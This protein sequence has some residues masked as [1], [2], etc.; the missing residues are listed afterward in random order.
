[1]RLSAEIARIEFGRTDKG[2]GCARKIVFQ[3]DKTDRQIDCQTDSESEVEHLLPGA[4][5][6]QL[7]LATIRVAGTGIQR[8]GSFDSGLS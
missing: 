3:V 8:I 5:L 4:P 7:N 6:F 2:G 1:M